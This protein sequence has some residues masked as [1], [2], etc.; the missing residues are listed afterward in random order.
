[1]LGLT[2]LQ[3]GS[4]TLVSRARNS[5][6]YKYNAM[7][8]ILSNGIWLLVM[9]KLVM[10]FEDPIMCLVYVVG[11]VTGSVLMQ[12]VSITYLEKKKA[13]KANG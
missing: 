1:M 5:G 11:A 9:R 4:F 13:P 6:S 8:S 12:W 3:N 2:I 10:N 7:A